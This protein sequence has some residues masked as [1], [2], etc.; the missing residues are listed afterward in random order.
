MIFPNKKIVYKN[1]VVLLQMNQLKRFLQGDI[2]WVDPSII[3]KLQKYDTIQVDSTMYQTADII[4]KIKKQ[5]CPHCL[6]LRTEV[7]ALKFQLKK[8]SAPDLPPIKILLQK[9]FDERFERTKGREFSRKELFKEVNIYLK[10]FDLQIMY[11]TDAAWRYLIED[12][13]QD[14]N[15]NYRKL[16]IKRR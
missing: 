7:T 12:I 9:F 1:H 2:D 6:Q 14:T 11:N 16:K 15:K 10:Q 3:T 5:G 8:V 4:E 13:I